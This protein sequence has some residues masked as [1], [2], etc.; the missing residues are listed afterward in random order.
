LTEKST[1]F[2]FFHIC[3]STQVFVCLATSH[4]KAVFDGQNFKCNCPDARVGG[5]PDAFERVKPCRWIPAYARMTGSYCWPD[6]YPRG[7]APSIWRA[8]AALSV[9]RHDAINGIQ[10]RAEVAALLA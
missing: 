7:Q 2:Q 10:T 8:A 1:N 9:T 4:R 6:T 3:R 5:H